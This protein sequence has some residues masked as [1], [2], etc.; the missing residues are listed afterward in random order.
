MVGFEKIE[1][2]SYAAIRVYHLCCHQNIP[3]KWKLQIL[4]SLDEVDT[5]VVPTI[6][7]NQV[8]WLCYNYYSIASTVPRLKGVIQFVA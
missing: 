4:S 3:C 7:M 6:V 5:K 2:S 8:G 1:Q